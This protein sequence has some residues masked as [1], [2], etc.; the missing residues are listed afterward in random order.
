MFSLGNRDSA[1]G[2]CPCECFF[3]HL[4][5]RA[6]ARPNRLDLRTIRAS[7]LSYGYIGRQACINQFIFSVAIRQLENDLIFLHCAIACI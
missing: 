6:Q 7:S 3:T 4:A 5:S 2:K 1:A